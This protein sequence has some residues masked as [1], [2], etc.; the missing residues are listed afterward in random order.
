MRYPLW[1]LPKEIIQTGISR[2]RPWMAGEGF[3]D[4]HCPPSL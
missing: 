3:R 4:A 2:E 1:G